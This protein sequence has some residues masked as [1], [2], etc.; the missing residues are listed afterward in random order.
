MGRIREI[1]DGT[2]QELQKYLQH[3]RWE[4]NPFAHGA[5]IGEYVLPGDD[6]IADIASHI[7]SYT[8]PILIHS[9]FSGVG[10]TTLLKMLLEE[11]SDEFTTTYI[12]EHNVTPYELTSIVADQIGVGK[13]S[14]TKLTEQKIRDHVKSYRGDPHLLGIDE[15]GLN[16]PDTLHT[17][18]FLNDLDRFRVIL[19]GMSSQWNAIGDLGSDGRAF[20]RRVS[21]KLE[22]EP[23][24]REQT[25]EL[26]QRRL[27]AAAGRD[28][29]NEDVLDDI[30]IGPF[31]TDALDTIHERAQGVP[32]V[33]T[34]ACAELVDLAAYQHAHDAGSEISVDL[35][36]AIEYTEPEVEETSE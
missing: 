36:E 26:V 14:S 35:T 16:D 20:Q 6:E 17:I 23:F 15:F 12:G 5:S 1:T 22:L 7:R 33:I 21:Y 27:A 30:G 34:A 28:P 10:K 4:R 8:G 3:H 11:Y 25:T 24:E 19:T 13:S 29:T 2:D 32:A 31:S 18:Q 9:R